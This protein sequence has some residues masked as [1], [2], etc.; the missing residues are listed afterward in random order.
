LSRTKPFE[1]SQAAVGEAYRRVKANKGAA[2][3]DGESIAEFEKDLE[4]NLYKIWNRMSSGTYFPPPVRSVEIPKDNGKGVRRLGVPT[5]SDRI[6]QMVVKLYLEPGVEP[7]FHPDSY[8]Y[9]PG[10][11]AHDALST[12]RQRCWRYDWAIDLDIRGFFD[13]LDWELVLRA[14]RKHTDCKWILLYI[15]RWLKAPI[16]MEDGTLQARDR[17]S[18]QGSVISPLISNIFMHHAFDEWMREKLPYVPFERYAD[19][20]L[21]HC[22]T[23]QQA[24]LVRDAIARRLKQCKLELHPEKTRIVY[25][26][27]NKRKGNYAH[28]RFDFLGYGFRPRSVRSQ[29]GHMFVSFS[30]AISDKAAKTIRRMIR[31][32]RLHLH[33]SKTLAELAESCNA[34]VRG[35]T[36]Y[37]GRF[38]KSALYPVFRGINFYLARWVERKYKRFRRRPAK[39]W[40]WLL[41]VMEQQPKLFAHWGLSRKRTAE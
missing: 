36:Q 25:C 40:E 4:N 28:E 17:G 9:R 12:A 14:V 16:Q 29:K 22:K 23:E 2:G 24:T 18:P 21:A 3:V 20:V 1:I 13:N 11:S 19:D 26:K 33:T 34:Q 41:Q 15:E 32:W 30:P 5:V 8:G 31:S 7:K 6:A 38:Y 37:Y 27:D 39:A 10:K 35:W